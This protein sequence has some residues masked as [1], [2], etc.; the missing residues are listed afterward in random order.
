MN[1]LK[2]QLAT[3][4]A[5][6][7]LKT[8]HIANAIDVVIR[9]DKPA[10]LA[11]LR[12]IAS[13]LQFS[14]INAADWVLREEEKQ[15][16]LEE[17]GVSDLDQRNANDEAKRFEDDVHGGV[18]PG[19]TDPDKVDAGGHPMAF[20]LQQ[21]PREKL[22]QVTQLYDGVI[23]EMAKL[24]PSVFDLPR[25]I[26][27][28][29]ENYIISSGNNV[30]ANEATLAALKAAGIDDQE[31]ADAGAQASAARQARMTQR[32]P[33]I[34]QVLE[35]QKGEGDIDVFTKLPIHTQLRIATG[36]WKGIFARRRQLVTYIAS[37]GKLD[38]LSD[39]VLLKEGLK[40]MQGWCEDFEAEHAILIEALVDSGVNVYGIDDAIAWS[41]APRRTS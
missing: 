27:E 12:S 18:K 33:A 30:P 34:L 5:S 37:S 19:Q 4:I 20:E 17:F 1:R 9:L 21:T 38:Q 26:K 11:G 23:A 31:F 22:Q 13:S 2:N 8:T 24:N 10:A 7:P 28:A 3:A 32:K 41:K 16:R 36:A 14:M 35:E 6:T 15:Q 40:T 29:V 39:A 25:P